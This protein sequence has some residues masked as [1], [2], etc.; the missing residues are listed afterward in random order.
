MLQNPQVCK[1]GCFVQ[2]RMSI[3]LGTKIQDHNIH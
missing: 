2:D 1:L 3:N